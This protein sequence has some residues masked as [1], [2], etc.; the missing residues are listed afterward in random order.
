MTKQEEIREGIARLLYDRECNGIDCGGF[1]PQETFEEYWAS[2]TE[3]EKRG[4]VEETL[5]YLKS[6]GV[7]IKVDKPLPTIDYHSAYPENEEIYQQ[8]M[9]EAGFVAVEELI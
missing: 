8:A 1:L 9:V 6:K 5:T 2:L 4:E 3:E 7:V